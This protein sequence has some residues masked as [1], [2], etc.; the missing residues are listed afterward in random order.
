MSHLTLVTRLL[1]AACTLHGLVSC[2]ISENCDPYGLRPEPAVLDTTLPDG[3]PAMLNVSNEEI[4]L[5]FADEAG[6]TIEVYYAIDQWNID[7]G[8]L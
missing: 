5:T 6:R 4:V 2:G 7:Q 1:L 8:D 3:R